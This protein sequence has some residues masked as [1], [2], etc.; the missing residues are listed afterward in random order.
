M[1]A[2]RP[3]LIFILLTLS[4]F[5][6][7][8]FF[9]VYIIWWQ[10]N[11]FKRS[12][13][14]HRCKIINFDQSIHKKTVHLSSLVGMTTRCWIVLDANNSYSIFRS[15]KPEDEFIFHERNNGAYFVSAPKTCRITSAWLTSEST[16]A[17]RMTDRDNLK[18]LE[19]NK[20]KRQA[21]QTMSTIAQRSGVAK[22]KGKRGRDSAEWRPSEGIKR[23]I[24]KKFFWWNKSTYHVRFGPP[25][26]PSLHRSISSHCI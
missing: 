18:E 16:C 9:V 22:R 5:F 12:I 13:K 11:Y 26:P 8:P 25:S 23:K 3:A 2:R 7:S 17:S 4:T 24:N 21:C 1:V 20:N 10:S 15:I 6:A 19:K 14:V